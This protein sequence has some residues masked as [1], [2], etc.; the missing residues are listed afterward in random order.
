MISISSKGNFKKTDKFFKDMTSLQYKSILD[1]YGREGVN[2]LM[3]ATPKDSGETANCWTYKISKTK[4][5]KIITWSNTNVING[6][7]IAILIQYGH[8]TRNGGC[9]QG[10]DFIN[11]AIRPIFDKISNDIWKEVTK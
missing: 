4:N 10:R 3:E 9:V 6:V 8:A 7:S 2:A 1:K 11:P 5:G